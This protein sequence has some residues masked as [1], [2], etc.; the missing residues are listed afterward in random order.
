MSS[1]SNERK[2]ESTE[3]GPASAATTRASARAPSAWGAVRDAV[4]SVH[5]LGALL[6]ST[7]VRYNDILDLLP[8]LRTG[9]GVLCALFEPA[10]T[11]AEAA[12][13]E[14]GQYGLGR[15]RELLAVLDATALADDERDD[16]TTQALRLAGEL[17]ASSDL[18]ALLDRAADPVRSSVSVRLIVR[19]TGRL[20]GGGRGGEIT[21]RFDDSPPDANIDVDPY[22]VGPLLSLVLA[23]TRSAGAEDVVVRAAGHGA[24]ACLTVEPVGAADARLRTVAVRILP[25]VPPAEST[26][27]RV[28]TQIG[29]V[30]ELQGARAVLRFPRGAG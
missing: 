9:A 2:T 16:L 21:V 30:L 4:S 19:E 26:A 25:L 5:N 22:V 14:V 24:E 7:S 3:P 23:L 27:R 29:A 1:E 13:R 6:R 17:E 11:A 18:L 12:T 20:W 8:E 28:A 15:A 10:S